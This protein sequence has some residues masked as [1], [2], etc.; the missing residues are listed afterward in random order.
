MEYIKQLNMAHINYDIVD[1]K[2]PPFASGGNQLAISLD[3]PSP[4]LTPLAV[5]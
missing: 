4:S 3:E 2:Q 5:T 1:I